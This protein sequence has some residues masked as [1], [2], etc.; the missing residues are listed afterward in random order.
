[1]TFIIFSQCEI[2]FSVEYDLE[3]E[4]NFDSS[5]QNKVLFFQSEI[6]WK[7]T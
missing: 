7:I 1:M 3:R 5:I 2:S 4:C 6:S